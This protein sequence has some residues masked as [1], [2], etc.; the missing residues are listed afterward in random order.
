MQK[1][2]LLFPCK[3]GEGKNLV[4]V[5]PA[6]LVETRAFEGCLSVATYT[7]EDSP[8]SV[9]LFEEW[10]SRAAQEKYLTWRIESGMMAL[11]EPILASPLEIHYLAE[12]AI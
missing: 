4:E 1:V 12:H 2:T 5:L 7:Y 6:V 3:P 8:D 9:L 11:L 10:E